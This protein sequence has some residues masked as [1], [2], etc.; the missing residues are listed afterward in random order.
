LKDDWS[1]L[2][3]CNADIFIMSGWEE[4]SEEK[5]KGW[6]LSS[7]FKYFSAGD[8]NLRVG[9][10]FCQ[11]DYRDEAFLFEGI[12]WGNRISNGAKTVLYFVAPRFSSVFLNA[13]SQI[14]GII[15]AK[16]VYWRERLTPCLY[17]LQEKE[18]VKSAVSPETAL[19]RPEWSTWEKQIN[20]VARNQLDVIRHFFAGLAKRRVRTVIEK[21]RIIFCWGSI[22]IAEIKAKGNRF[23]LATKVKWTRNKAIAAKF[24]KSGWVDSAG[25]INEDFR[26]AVY[27]I[28]ELL[29]NIEANGNI[30]NKD[31]FALKVSSDKDFLPLYF[32]KHIEYPWLNKERSGLADKSSLYY[33]CDD[34]QVNVIYPILEKPIQKF[35]SALLI[36]SA[37]E[38]S[39]LG[40]NGLPH[41]A[42][43]KWNKKIHLFSLPIFLEELRLCQSWLK[44]C[45]LFPI[46]LLSEEWK[47][48]GLKNVR[49]L[50]PLQGETYYK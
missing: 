6:H 33:F 23:E 14:K 5:R 37:L 34:S 44:D 43:V 10:I 7:H 26:R 4:C 40:I 18:Y 45:A 29:E 15:S 31:L 25:N 42:Q 13:L 8:M 20:P 12:L 46:Y 28:L 49:E 35:I 30:D 21:S 41:N 36:Y 16:A 50:L 38:H 27:G 3:D 32:G 11:D 22:E 39:R 1:A 47:T 24:L 2:W 9:I 17:P 48:V 19:P